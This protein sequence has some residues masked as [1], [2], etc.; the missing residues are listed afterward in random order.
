VSFEA[1]V[2]RYE[3]RVFRTCRH[4]LG[5]DADAEEVT[6]DVFLRL[7]RGLHSFAEKASFSTWLFRIVHNEC[8][9]RYGK[10][11]RRAEGREEYV[12]HRMSERQL[13]HVEASQTSALGDRVQE[14]LSALPE[15]DRQVL[16]LRYVSDLSLKDMARALGIKLSAAKMRLYRAQQRFRK[17]YEESEPTT[18]PPPQPKL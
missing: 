2:S 9:T 4:Y 8:A 17:R 3:T 18:G 15:D 1:L 12:R 11:K 13:T 5:S 10:I 7:F 16:V 6:Q 14:A